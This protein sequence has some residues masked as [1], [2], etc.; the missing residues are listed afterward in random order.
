MCQ[1]SRH[2]AIRSSAFVDGWIP[3]LT[4]DPD[5]HGLSANWTTELFASSGVYLQKDCRP[6]TR[7]ADCTINLLF[8]SCTISMNKRVINIITMTKPHMTRIYENDLTSEEWYQRRCGCLDNAK[9][10]NT[11]TLRV[12]MHGDYNMLDFMFAPLHGCW[13]K[14][15]KLEI[16]MQAKNIRS[17]EAW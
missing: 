16:L 15:L 4:M 1:Y 3:K 8:S 10:I 5:E 17:E 6:N 7:I 12:E 11:E 9:V 2:D 14:M 13:R